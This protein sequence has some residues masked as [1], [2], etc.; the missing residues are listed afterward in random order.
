MDVVAP[1]IPAKRG[2]KPKNSVTS[3][4]PIKLVSETTLS[5]S[6][7]PVLAPKQVTRRG[8]KPKQVFHCEEDQNEIVSYVSDDENLVL[9]LRVKS[10]IRDDEEDSVCFGTEELNEVDG[11]NPENNFLPLPLELENEC[12]HSYDDVKCAHESDSFINSLKVVDLLK[13][14]EEK[15]KLNE[16]PSNT[17]ISCYWCCHKFNNTPFGI[18]VKFSDKKFHVYGCFCSLECAASYNM[19]NKDSVDELWERYNLINML[20]RRLGHKNIIKPAPNRLSLKMF[21]GHMDIEEFR[22]YCE[23]SKV[24]NINFPPMMTIT[25]QIEEINESDLNN[26]FRYIPIDTDR[27][28]RFKEKMK[29][30][31]TKPVTNFKNTLDHTMNLKYMN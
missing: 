16:W 19:T 2:R 29:L 18:P 23:T 25:Q 13:D 6:N 10:P 27:I 1:K 3:T 26:D 21:G 20:S 8:R 31:R 14:F 12:I 9:N 30:K 24:I 15:N 4:T 5:L 11:Y 17:S 7:E 28:N 22:R